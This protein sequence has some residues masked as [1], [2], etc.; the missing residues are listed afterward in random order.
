MA[1]PADGTIF[2]QLRIAPNVVRKPRAD[3]KS[4]PFAS[5]DTLRYLDSAPLIVF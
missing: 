4:F 5:I 3:F 2:P 1:K